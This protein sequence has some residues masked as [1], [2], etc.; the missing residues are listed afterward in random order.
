MDPETG[1]KDQGGTI[2]YHSVQKERE[3]GNGS[4]WDRPALWAGVIG[5]KDMAQAIKEAEPRLRAM[6]LMEGA[7]CQ[8]K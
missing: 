5:G 3:T 4:Q 8:M 2:F 7:S 6:G 1:Q